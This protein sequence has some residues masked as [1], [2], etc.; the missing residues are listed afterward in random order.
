MKRRIQRTVEW[1]EQQKISIHRDSQSRLNWSFD[2]NTLSGQIYLKV[3]MIKER[4]VQRE[5]SVKSS[6]FH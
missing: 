6:T 3:E 1:V 4:N 5:K 2:A